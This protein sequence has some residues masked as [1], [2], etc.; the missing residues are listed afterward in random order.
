MSEEIISSM[1]SDIRETSVEGDW[2]EVSSLVVFVFLP[3]NLTILWR[4]SRL[5]WVGKICI[6]EGRLFTVTLSFITYRSLNKL[7][8]HFCLRLYHATNIE[9][10][11]SSSYTYYTSWLKVWSFCGK[12]SELMFLTLAL[13]PK[14]L[15]VFFCLFFISFTGPLSQSRLF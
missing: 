6:D 7:T 12:T 5:D 13:W 3:W 15:V 8:L 11:V 10:Y 14:S 9:L 4:R 1:D 2:M